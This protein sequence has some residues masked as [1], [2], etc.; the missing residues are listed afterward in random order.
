MTARQ[1]TKLM[2]LNLPT[3]IVARLN[4]MADYAG[5]SRHRFLVNLLEV[6][7]DDITLFKYVGIFQIA[8]LI[9]DT[10]EAVRGVS[11]KDDDG[12]EKP[13]PVKLDE[14]TLEKLDKLADQGK[15]TRHQLAVNIV[16]IGLEEAEALKKCGVMRGF[17]FFR[18]LSD[19]FRAFMGKG[20]KAYKASVDEEQ[21]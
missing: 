17:L 11:F 7:I 19:R 20:E 8:V 4:I 14:L 21:K 6:G 13:I 2:T 3:E 16:K 5:L 15:I 12:P 9:R 1:N 18:D 10:I